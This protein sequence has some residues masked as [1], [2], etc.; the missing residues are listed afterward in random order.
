MCLTLNEIFH[1]GLHC[2]FFLGN[3]NDDVCYS[4]GM[5]MG[6][7]MH[8][9]LVVPTFASYGFNLAE[10]TNVLWSKTAKRFPFHLIWWLGLPRWVLRSLN[11]SSLLLQHNFCCLFWHISEDEYRNCLISLPLSW[12]VLSG[13]REKIFTYWRAGEENWVSPFL[14]Q[15]TKHRYHQAL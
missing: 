8:W 15:C 7:F 12:K 14:S 1:Y 13:L 9:T 10:G 2:F 4:S 5:N 3:D 6:C 11:G